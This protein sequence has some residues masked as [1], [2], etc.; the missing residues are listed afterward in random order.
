MLSA[1]SSAF[2]PGVS[3]TK[4]EGGLF[5]WAILPESLDAAAVLRKALD[6][7]VAFVPGSSF[8]ADGSGKNAMRLNF[9][10]AS[11]ERIEEGIARLGR[12]LRRFV[13]A[14]RATVSSWAP[15]TGTNSR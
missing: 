4:P 13:Q 1:M 9:T 7:K 11:L 3:W 2:P 10:N 12:V 6:E 8:F 14:G 5:V 15:A